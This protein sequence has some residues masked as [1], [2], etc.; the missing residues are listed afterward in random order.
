MKNAYL[1]IKIKKLELYAVC[2]LMSFISS[3][4]YGKCVNNGDIWKFLGMID[5]ELNCLSGDIIR[6]YRMGQFSEE[7]S[8]ELY[9]KMVILDIWKIKNGYEDFL[10]HHMKGK[11]RNI[12]IIQ[13]SGEVVDQQV[14]ILDYFEENK[15]RLAMCSEMEFKMAYQ[16]LMELLDEALEICKIDTSSDGL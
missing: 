14:R 7:E 6:G 13:I 4:T 3:T 5:Q 2:F 16:A 11:R 8:R 15:G 10:M 9:R 1:M 12:E